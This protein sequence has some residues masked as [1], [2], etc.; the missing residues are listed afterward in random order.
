MPDVEEG[1][2][3]EMVTG[4]VVAKAKLSIGL[5]G[6]V[7]KIGF[8]GGGRMATAM[9]GA[10]CKS[11]TVVAHEIFVSD[12]SEER[13]SFL[14]KEYAVNVYSSNVYVVESAQTVIVAVKPS[15]MAGVLEEIAAKVSSKHL[16]VSIAAGCTTGSIE[17]VLPMVRLVRVMPNLACIVEEAMSA[18]C[19]GSRATPADMRRVGKLLVSF[20]K[21]IELP[22]KLFDAVTAVSGSGPAFFAYVLDKMVEGGVAEGLEREDALLLA[23]Q[24]MLGTAKVLLERDLDPRDLIKEVASPKGTTVAGLSV[25]DQSSTTETLRRVVGAAADRSR[26]LAV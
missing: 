14:K 16:I 26:E 13:R 11:R 2:K 12:K 25:F 19:A 18:Y 24:T 20:G 10:M 5:A 8:I 7:M 9:I 3:T 6:E 15:E 23:K 1:R 21:A 4:R 17:A 22:E